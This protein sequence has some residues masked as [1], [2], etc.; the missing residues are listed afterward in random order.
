MLAGQFSVK[1]GKK[2]LWACRNSA[3]HIDAYMLCIFSC[4]VSKQ[5][6]KTDG[7]KETHAC[8]YLA[9]TMVQDSTNVQRPAHDESLQNCIWQDATLN[10]RVYLGYLKRVLP[11][12]AAGMLW[13]EEDGIECRIQN[14]NVKF[15]AKTA[16]SLFPIK[17]C[18]GGL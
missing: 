2:A 15:K 5:K 17:F 9:A 6:K 14:S 11:L 16:L 4:R 1:L 10:A 8:R 13:R 3:Q 18:G 12:V 7:K